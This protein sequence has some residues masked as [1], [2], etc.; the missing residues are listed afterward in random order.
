M[1][2]SRGKG[3]SV[4]ETGADRAVDPGFAETWM[5]SEIGRCLRRRGSARTIPGFQDLV[6]VPQPLR[7]PIHPQ[8][9]NT[10]VRLGASPAVRPLDL[11][12][13]MVLAPDIFGILSKPARIALAQAS[14]LA[15]IACHT[16]G[17]LSHERQVA[18][19]L[20]YQFFPNSSLRTGQ[21]L[22]QAEALEL[23]F[24]QEAEM[25]GYLTM[26]KNP[27]RIAG[28][29]GCRGDLPKLEYLAHV[30]RTCREATAGQ[31]P[32]IF[33]LGMG[34]VRE[35]I[36]LAVT[37]TADVIRLTGLGDAYGFAPNTAEAHIGLPTICGLAAARRALVD[38]GWEDR[39]DIVIG[40][41]IRDGADVAKA[42]ALGAKAVNVGRGV[43]PAL[44]CLGCGTCFTGRCP[45]GIATQDPDSL[46]K[47]NIED[48]AQKVYNYI[49]ALNNEAKQ[50]C[51]VM[52]KSDVAELGTEDVQATSIEASIMTGL[53]LVGTGKVF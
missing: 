26:E 22:L 15:G 46:K 23:I 12:I 2:L 21:D 43:L 51:A 16:D 52:G 13:P 5:L 14:G 41:G 34:R 1:P 49:I 48:A 9:V 6:F 31:I 29:P 28:S 42:L 50:I 7:L 18:T 40:G 44:G 11:A 32:I 33:S 45:Q 19:Q 17:M 30:I 20:V 39:V 25:G 8:E 4:K 37:L 38:N 24:G 35:D 3:Q 47:F 36:R 53:P 10:A 27:P